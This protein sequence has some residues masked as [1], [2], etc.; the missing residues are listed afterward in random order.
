MSRKNSIKT[1]ETSNTR[2]KFKSFLK[3]PT[4]ISSNRVK[5]RLRMARS[6]D[7]QNSSKISER[8]HQQNK[9]LR[10]RRKQPSESIE[11]SRNWANKY[12]STLRLFSSW[13]STKANKSFNGTIVCHK[14]T[15]NNPSGKNISSTNVSHHEIGSQ[16]SRLSKYKLSA[17]NWGMTFDNS[18]EKAPNPTKLVHANL[19]SRRPSGIVRPKTSIGRNH[20]LY[21]NSKKFN[22]SWIETKAAVEH[23]I[24]Q[25]SNSEQGNIELYVSE[26]WT[27]TNE[28][29]ETPRANLSQWPSQGQPRLTKNYSLKT[30]FEKKRQTSKDFIKNNISY[31]NKLSSKLRNNKGILDIIHNLNYVLIDILL[32]AEYFL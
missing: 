30:I 23:Y 31:V 20:S 5:N 4:Q 7:T 15:Q 32:L 16:S 17:T 26:P 19:S 14:K 10:K 6:N 8:S 21:T 22:Q 12:G 24:S 18:R 13:A 28:V 29:D 11:S 27:D 1:I 2:G 25:R 3:Q 9:I